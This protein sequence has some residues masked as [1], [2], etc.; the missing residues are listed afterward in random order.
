[1][2][3]GDRALDRPDHWKT[4]MSLRGLIIA[5]HRDVGYFLAGVVVIYAIS[6]LA[7]NHVDDWNPNFVVE[8]STVA[9]NLPAARESITRDDVVRVLEPLGEEANFLSF[10]FPTPRRIKIYLKDGSVT[11]TLGSRE[12]EYETIRRRPFFFESNSLHVH[13]RGWWLWFSDFFAAALIL[14]TLTGLF[15]LQGRQGLK[16]RGKWL[17]AAGIALPVA[18]LLAV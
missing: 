14:L 9:L 2:G 13:P 18:A 4:A 7:L 3:R 15:V 17:V 6:G 5:A 12:G 10:D 8:R 1:M 16:G 11:G